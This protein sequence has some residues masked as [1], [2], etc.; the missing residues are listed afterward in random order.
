M[1]G[2]LLDTAPFQRKVLEIA[3]RRGQPLCVPL[4]SKLD[5][6]SKVEIADERTSRGDDVD[7]RVGRNI[8][9]EVRSIE[10][11]PELTIETSAMP[12]F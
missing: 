12:L 9:I 5:T 1:N 11:R 6:T 7:Q 8:A 2:C 10:D 3:T 4:F